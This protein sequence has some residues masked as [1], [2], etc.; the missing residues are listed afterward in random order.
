MLPVQYQAAESL[1]VRKFKKLIFRRG[2]GEQNRAEKIMNI[3]QI[4]A[5]TNF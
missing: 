3:H 4:K 1:I 2:R 5:P